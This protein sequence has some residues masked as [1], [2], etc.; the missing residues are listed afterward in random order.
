MHRN[1]RNP[2]GRQLTSQHISDSLS[3]HFYS[4]NEWRRGIYRALFVIHF[5]P[6]RP[7]FSLALSSCTHTQSKLLSRFSTHDDDDDDGLSPI[8]HCIYANLLSCSVIIDKRMESKRKQQ[9]SSSTNERAVHTTNQ[10][11]GLVPARYRGNSERGPVPLFEKK[12]I[13]DSCLL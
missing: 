3:I 11:P 12:R 2:V 5:Q 9:R 6:G 13:E 8:S 4:N 1:K 10:P 7:L